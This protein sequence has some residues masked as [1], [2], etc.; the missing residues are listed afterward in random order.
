MEKA[1]VVVAAPGTL[2][3]GVRPK[4]LE[5]GAAFPKREEGVTAARA[6]AGVVGCTGLE[7]RDRAGD[8]E[9]NNPVPDVPAAPCPVCWLTAAEGVIEG[10]GEEKREVAPC[11]EGVAPQLVEAGA[12]ACVGAGVDVEDAIAEDLPYFFSSFSTNSASL[13]A[14]FFISAGISCSLDGLCCL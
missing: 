6:G 8:G 1:F 7:K 13:P 10:A 3:P 5:D 2:K 12:A 14:Y 11:C 9:P 4:E